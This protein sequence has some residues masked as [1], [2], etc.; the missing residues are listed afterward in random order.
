M[1][2]TPEQLKKLRE[3]KKLSTLDIAAH[4]GLPES[5]I[6]QIE[7]GEVVASSKDLLRI[8]KVIAE[9]VTPPLE[10][11]DISPDDLKKRRDFLEDGENEQK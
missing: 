2:I 10:P 11:D 7:E 3:G 1:N 4:I 8:Y 5:Y 6:Q 9:M